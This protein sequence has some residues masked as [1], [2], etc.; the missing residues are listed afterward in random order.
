MSDQVGNPEDRFSHNEARLLT[1]ELVYAR[2]MCSICLLG[3]FCG[4]LLSQ[5]SISR[6]NKSLAKIVATIMVLKLIENL[7]LDVYPQY[8]PRPEKTGFLHLRKQ[9]RRSASR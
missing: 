6:E 1:V 5:I 2:N 8:K 9:R 3:Y 4:N 7:F